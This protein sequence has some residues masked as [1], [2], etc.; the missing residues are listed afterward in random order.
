M[1]KSVGGSTN[2]YVNIKS[3]P[4]KKLPPEP[5]QRERAPAAQCSGRSGGVSKACRH[6]S[7]CM[8]ACSHISCAFLKK[9]ISP[10]HFMRI[11]K[12]FLR[13]FHAHKKNFLRTFHAHKKK[14]TS[15]AHFLR[16]KKKLPPHI[17]CACMR[18]LHFL[19]RLH[20]HLHAKPKVKKPKHNRADV[21]V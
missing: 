15:P 18:H 12:K 16:I 10:A 2:S 1:A 8:R 11:K 7:R 5:T 20:V 13:T 3:G 9:E 14:E 4:F 19:L 17:S 6:H 21:L